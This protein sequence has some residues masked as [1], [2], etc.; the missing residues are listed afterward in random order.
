MASEFLP[1]ALAGIAIAIGP[2]LVMSIYIARGRW[3][4]WKA[5]L[6]GW[7]GWFIA[8]VIRIIPV[9]LPA[10]F[11]ASELAANTALLLLYIAFASAMAGLFEEGMRYLFLDQR[12]QLRASWK[13]LL[14]FGLGWGVGEAM[15]IYVP[16]IAALPFLAEKLPSFLEILPGAI[17]RNIAILAHIGFTFIVLRSVTG[18]EKGKRFL[19]LAMFLHF[20]LNIASASA[21][22]LTEN[23]WLTEAVAAIITIAILV[24]AYRLNT[25]RIP[26]PR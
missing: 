19:L 24:I 17:E 20:T 22:I 1:A 26:R 11:L 8:L 9:Q 23:V 14:S 5:F 21:L 15:I 13:G 18:R 7:G 16:S 6:F 3:S 25:G 10:A 4:L 2:F 12:K